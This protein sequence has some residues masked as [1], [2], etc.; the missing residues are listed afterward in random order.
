VDNRKILLVDDVASMR[1]VIKAFLHSGGHTQ[2]DSAHDGVHARQQINN[3]DYAV[4]ICDL[5]MPKMNGIELLQY[6]RTQ[7]QQRHVQFV[8]VTAHNN[9]DNI[10]QAMVAGV[11]DYIAKP[12]QPDS[13]IKKVEKALNNRIKSIVEE[14]E[15]QA[16]EEI[17]IETGE[18]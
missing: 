13:L 15:Q 17:E 16:Y 7:H 8:M 11:N 14:S 5:E 2:I 3:N 6:V 9:K 4:V 12:F 10:K 18:D 1:D